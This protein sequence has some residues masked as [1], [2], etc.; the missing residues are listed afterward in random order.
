MSDF[1]WAKEIEL[2]GEDMEQQ[3]SDF[4]SE[5]I[6]DTL[7]NKGIDVTSFAWSLNVE[8]FPQENDDE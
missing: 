4:I 7:R 8:Y 5:T 6:Y 2:C 3:E 1:F